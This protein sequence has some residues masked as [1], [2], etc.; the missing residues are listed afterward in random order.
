MNSIS[1]YHSPKINPT[2]CQQHFPGTVS[3]PLITNSSEWRRNRLPPAKRVDSWNNII[4]YF[5]N[6][7]PF[8]VAPTPSSFHPSIA[9]TGLAIS[10]GWISDHSHSDPTQSLLLLVLRGRGPSD[11]ENR[12]MVKEGDLTFSNPSPLF[13]GVLSSH[14]RTGPSASFHDIFGHPLRRKL[15]SSPPARVKCEP[16]SLPHSEGDCLGATGVA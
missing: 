10:F 13:F 9:A 7:V 1:S 2:K 3:R 8:T 16:L 6:V 14:S 12:D 15:R 4:I 11:P 5:P